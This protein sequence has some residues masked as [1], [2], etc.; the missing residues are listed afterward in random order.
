MK[1]DVTRERNLDLSLPVLSVDIEG[2][3]EPV[4][5]HML[6]PSF[7]SDFTV[8]RYPAHGNTIDRFSYYTVAVGRRSFTDGRS[9]ASLAFFLSVVSALVFPFASALT[10]VYSYR[11]LRRLKRTHERGAP[12]AAAGL[13][14]SVM[15]VA[16]VVVVFTDSLLFRW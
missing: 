2:M 11:V 14:A 8:E 6:D 10:L 16:F 7:V 4:N 3:R 9:E 15:G 12:W 13:V 1:P 5:S